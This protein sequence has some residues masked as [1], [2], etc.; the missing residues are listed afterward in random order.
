MKADE[1]DEAIRLHN[2]MKEKYAEM[3]R[4]IDERIKTAEESRDR[5]NYLMGYID[6][7]LEWLKSLRE[8]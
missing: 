4:M 3:L 2:E 8:Q 1:I 5:N 6:A 7:M